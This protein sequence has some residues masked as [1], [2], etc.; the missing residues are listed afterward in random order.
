MVVCQYVGG[1]MLKSRFMD[2]VLS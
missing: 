1:P 2:S